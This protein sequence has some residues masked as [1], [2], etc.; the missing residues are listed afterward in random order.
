MGL[1]LALIGCD[2]S[3]SLLT[4]A[5][6][7]GQSALI[8]SCLGTDVGF[9]NGYSFTDA[10]PYWSDG[11]VPGVYA[12]KQSYA[13]SGGC[14]VSGVDPNSTH[15]GN[16]FCTTINNGAIQGGLPAY[17]AS[18]VQIGNSIEANMQ[19]MVIAVNFSTSV[20]EFGCTG[21][22]TNCGLIMPCPA[23]APS[24]QTIFYL[25]GVFGGNNFAT[26]PNVATD[27]TTFAQNFSS[28]YSDYITSSGASCTLGAGF[29]ASSVC[30]PS[31]D[32]PFTGAY[33]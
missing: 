16:R 11:S 23:S 13:F 29:N 15:Y 17:S 2:S 31:P 1:P 30:Y 6:L 14:V 9:V 21:T 22:M 32:D 18:S 8:G 19:Y 24:G 28:G 33:P 10:L 7:S 4:R 27:L 26:V 25:F 5:A 12:I 3:C 20:V